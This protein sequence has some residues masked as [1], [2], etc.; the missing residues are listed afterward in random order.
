MCKICANK[1]WGRGWIKYLMG[2][3]D[4]VARLAK[5]VSHIKTNSLTRDNVCRNSLKLPWMLLDLKIL[6][7]INWNPDA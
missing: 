3:V 5:D 1:S 2:W 6:F 7:Q 4:N